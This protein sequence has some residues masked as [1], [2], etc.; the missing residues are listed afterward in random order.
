MGPIHRVAVL[1]PASGGGVGAGSAI[2]SRSTDRTRGLPTWTSTA[3]C[4]TVPDSFGWARRTVCFAM[5]AG[6]FAPTRRRKACPR[7][8]LR[9]CTRR[10]MAKSGSAPRRGWHGSKAILSRQSAPARAMSRTPSRRMRSATSTS[11]PISA[12]WWPRRAV[13]GADASF[14]S[15]PLQARAAPSS[16]STELASNPPDV[17]GMAAG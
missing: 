9:R 12:C 8:R 1:S 4:R 15:L 2:A 5:T 3:S 17:S 16:P 6:S 13:R 10:P 14:A 7:R 11:G